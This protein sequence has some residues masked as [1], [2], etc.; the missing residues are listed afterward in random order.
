MS[1]WDDTDAETCTH[2]PSHTRIAHARAH[3]RVHTHTHAQIDF[4]GDEVEFEGEEIRMGDLPCTCSDCCDK[5]EL[6]R[7]LTTVFQPSDYAINAGGMNLID[8]ATLAYGLNTSFDCIYEN[9]DYGGGGVCNYAPM[10]KIL[11]SDVSYSC[12]GWFS[13]PCQFNSVLGSGPG[14]GAKYCRQQCDIEPSCEYWSY[15]FEEGV[16][17]CFLKEKFPDISCDEY[18][19]WNGKYDDPNWY[20]FSGPATC[21]L[22]NA[23]YTNTPSSHEHGTTGGSIGVG[24]RSVTIWKW[25]GSSDKLEMVWDS[26]T[27]MEMATKNVCVYVCVCVCVCGQARLSKCECAYMILRT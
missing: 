13:G 25:D 9:A 4:D 14:M 22:S 1:V 20:G 16:H 17:E 6:G 21:S 18:R 12:P 23:V 24:G 26:G 3:T 7:L 10:I 2:W 27:D 8:S 11:Y 15:E 5:T 19:W